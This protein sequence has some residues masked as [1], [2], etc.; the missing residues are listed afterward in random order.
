VATVAGAGSSATGAQTFQRQ[1][2]LDAAGQ[3]T[4]AQRRA[5]ARQTAVSAT[6]TVAARGVRVKD[7]QAA[8]SASGVVVVAQRR[9]LQRQAATSAVGAVVVAGAHLSPRQAAISASGQVVVAPRR[10]L[11]RQVATSATGLVTVQGGVAGATATPVARV[12]LSA[13][14]EPDTRTLHKLFVRA[15]KNA[16]TGTVTLRAAVYEGASNRSGQLESSALT[17][18]LAEYTLT[19]GDSQA[20]TIGSYSDLEVR[21]WGNSTTGDTVTVEVADVRLETPPGGSIVERAA[22][23]S[24][25]ALIASSGSLPIK[26]GQVAITARAE[27]SPHPIVPPPLFVP[28]GVVLTPGAAERQVAISA[29]AQGQAAPQR[30]L[31]RQVVASAVGLVSAS[32]VRVKSRQVALAATATIQVAKLRIV[33]RQAAVASTGQVQVTPRRVL[34]RQAALTE[35]C[36]VTVQGGVSGVKTGQAAVTAVTTIQVVPRRIRF[37]QVAVGA[38]SQVAVAAEHYGPGPTEESH[39]ELGGVFDETVTSGT[40]AEH[41]T[42]GVVVEYVRGGVVGEYSRNGRVD[43]PARGAV[44][45]GEGTRSGNF[46]EVTT[47][48]EVL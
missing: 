21:F 35:T 4:A 27:P 29:S 46:D 13:G 28:A 44:P 40:V 3:V 15:R 12:S 7:R 31:Q 33:S 30:R 2:A 36:T 34:L 41:P 26:F 38:V 19:I 20:A 8:I 22:A 9:A 5:L 10:A 24:A 45:E 18:S 23:L 43:E 6:G 16:G 32:G 14:T 48:G 37:R 17:T 42:G 25:T 47:G 1:V 39:P 11:Q